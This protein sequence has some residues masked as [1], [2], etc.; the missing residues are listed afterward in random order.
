MTS[1]LHVFGKNP[2]AT[3]TPQHPATSA[4]EVMRAVEW[5]NKREIR[6]NPQRPMPKITHPTDVIVHITATTI[7]GSDLHLYH[8][9]IPGMVKGDIMG[10]EAVGVVNEVGEHVTHIKPG[11][12]VVIS[13]VIS[14]G[15]CD[16]CRKGH[17]SCC[18]TTNPSSEMEEMYGHRTAAL[19]G[20]SHL[21][22][23]YEGLQAEYARVP[24]GDV[25]CLKI[26]NEL[27]EENAILLSDVACTGW[28]AAIECG[29][30]KEGHV[31]GIWGAGPIGLM[32]AIWSLY[33]GAKRVIVIDNVHSRLTMAKDRIG[34]EIINFDEHKDVVCRM[35]ELVPGGI[36]V[37]IDAVGFRYSK[38]LRHQVQRM[39]FIETDAID[40]INECVKCV[41][42]A[43]VFAIVGDYVGVANGFP[44]GAIMEKAITIRT[45]QLFC[46]KYWHKIL[47]L[48]VNQKVHPDP[49]QLLIT[50][51]MKL[52]DAPGAYKMFDEKK[53]GI[54]KVLMSCKPHMRRE[55]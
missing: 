40:V 50:H 7:C 41:K 16:Y 30:V 35:N 46:Q 23:G 34:C 14:C 47:N 15:T 28:H 20:Y 33:A 4:T 13:A 10:H 22:G 37:A 27:S 18:D 44:I 36:D 21:T 29:Q 31:V 19:F 53:D 9:E 51:H 17:F 32:A 38:T 26:P 43:G 11:D 55:E 6:V 54:I 39:M 45:G 52:D 42:K 24:F 12:R 25:N 8:N 1:L 5:H 3:S 49:G 48:L 2:V